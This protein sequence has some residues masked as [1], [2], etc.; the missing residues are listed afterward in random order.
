MTSN[1]FN[2]FIPETL[3][4]MS[5]SILIPDEVVVSKIY[6]IRGQ[7]VMLIGIS[8]AVWGKNKGI[9]AGSEILTDSRKTSCSR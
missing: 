9:K 1:L 6:L 5:K 7:K 2:I 3:A 4:E 8:R